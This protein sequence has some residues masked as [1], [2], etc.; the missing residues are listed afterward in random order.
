MT[1]CRIIP[2]ALPAHSNTFNRVGNGFDAVKPRKVPQW[3]FL[4]NSPNMPGIAYLAGWEIMAN[5]IIAVHVAGLQT[6]DSGHY[7]S[8]EKSR[9]V[10]HPAFLCLGQ[11]AAGR[12]SQGAI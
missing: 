4:P 2:F 5:P 6:P 8:P 9:M 10:N 7:F 3:L 11:D 1:A 12:T